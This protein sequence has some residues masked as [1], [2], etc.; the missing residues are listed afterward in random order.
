M[1]NSLL[2]GCGGGSVSGNNGSSNGGK[3]V[4]Y[5]IGS[6][7]INHLYFMRFLPYKKLCEEQTDQRTNKPSCRD[8]TKSDADVE[9]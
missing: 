7:L 9:W 8:H 1:S 3:N 2:G 4:W 6:W 5:K